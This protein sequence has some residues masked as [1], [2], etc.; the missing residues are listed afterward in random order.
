VTDTGVYN[1]DEELLVQ[2]GN[3]LSE[4]T[5]TE[6]CARGLKRYAVGFSWMTFSFKAFTADNN[7]GVEYILR[8]GAPTGLYAPYSI[9]PQVLS[10]RSLEGSGVPVPKVYWGT[11]DTSWI[12]A[13]F[14]ICE[15]VG[16]IAVLP[17]E[18]PGLPPLE[19]EYRDSLAEQFI[20]ALARIHTLDWQ[21]QPIA[22][23][24]DG[25]SVENAAM[26]QIEEWESGISRWAS[27]AFP[28]L[29]W[30]T[31]WLKDNCPT[32]PRL[33]IVHGDYRTGNFLEENGDITAILDWE[34]AHLGDPHEDIGWLSLPMYKGGSPLLCRLVDE[35]DF[36]RRYE[37]KTG[38]RVS[39]ES[40][41]FYRAFSLYKL[42]ITHI[43]ASDCF[44]KARMND[45]RMPA[46]GS[47]IPTALRQ[48][49][50]TIEGSV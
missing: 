8:V 26:K 7:E 13:P 20:D 12:G 45:L 16:G 27:R 2:I 21:N 17:W 14:F 41:R 28:M 3:F 29:K 34:L 18:S 43:A 36:Y 49:M 22:E 42:A 40:V 10:S 9:K 32:A 31:N 48:M 24:A 38:I 39:R 50:K 47:Q 37:D 35:D 30:G 23:M 5:D 11:D 25:L 44:E 4:Q 46:M 6:V 33:S 1:N 19:G 15:K